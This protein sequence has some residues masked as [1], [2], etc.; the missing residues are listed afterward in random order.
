MI[1][2]DANMAIQHVLLAH[3]GLAVRVVLL[4]FGEF[5]VL[6]Q[7][8]WQGEAMSAALQN[9]NC[10]HRSRYMQLLVLVGDASLRSSLK[11]TSTNLMHSQED[12]DPAPLGS[13][14]YDNITRER[15][16]RAWIHKSTSSTA[17]QGVAAKGVGLQS[18]KDAGTRLWA[19]PDAVYGASI[20]SALTFSGVERA[21]ADPACAYVLSHQGEAANG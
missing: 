15:Q 9:W 1:A 10:L 6:P 12:R 19:D 17:A 3:W 8:T 5:L 13:G 11:K 18:G 21:P 14:L 20:S 2:H 16:R 7:K 4:K